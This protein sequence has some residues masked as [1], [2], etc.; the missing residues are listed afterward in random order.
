[1]AIIPWA[2]NYKMAASRLV[3]I[4]EKVRNAIA[5]NSSPKSKKNAIKFGVTLFKSE[6]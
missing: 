5:E 6:I 2:L 4:T 1:M 3:M